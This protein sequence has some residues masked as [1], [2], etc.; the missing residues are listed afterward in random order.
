MLTGYPNWFAGARSLRKQ[1][2]S[3]IDDTMFLVLNDGPKR[4][5]LILLRTS[6]VVFLIQL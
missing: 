4:S 1:V 2:S 5:A 3:E 6:A